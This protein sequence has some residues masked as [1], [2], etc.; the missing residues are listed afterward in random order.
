MHAVDLIY[1]AI[2][3]SPDAITS[4]GS[5]GKPI[6]LPCEPTKG[7]CSLTGV[8]TDVIP[9][10]Y[11]LGGS[12]T[13]WDLLQAPDSEMIGVSAYYALSFWAERMSSWICDGNKFV[14]IAKKLDDEQ[15]PAWKQPIRNVVL[16][17]ASTIIDGNQWAM[18]ITTSYKKHGALNAHVN[19]EQYG[20]IRFENI[21]VD[22]RDREIN[23]DWYFR[24]LDYQSSGIYRGCLESGKCYPAVVREIGIVEAQKFENWA[25]N[26]IDNPLYQFL[27]YLLPS[28]EEV[29]YD[30][31]AT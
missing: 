18:Y 6:E 7:I 10:K 4:R 13:N 30:S 9:R 15:N 26:K 2:K 3:D 19:K 22:C 23:R 17:G 16:D 28:A 12:F 5:R 11:L 29:K 21:T 25:H 8:E 24:L 20:F 27:C 31:Q 14:R 1:N